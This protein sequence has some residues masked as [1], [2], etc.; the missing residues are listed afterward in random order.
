MDSTI[1]WGVMA[2]IV[3]AVFGWVFTTSM[4]RKTTNGLSLLGAPAGEAEA[5]LWAQRLQLEGIWSQVQN[6]QGHPY[7]TGVYAY[8]VWVRSNDYDRA[9]KVL[10][11]VA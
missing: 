8:Q 11:L 5:Q 9:R 2:A 1:A 4:R 7:P 6:I 10:G 3:V